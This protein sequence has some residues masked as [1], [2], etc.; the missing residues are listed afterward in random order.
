QNR[1]LLW[2]T[3]I[4]IIVA[5]IFILLFVYFYISKVIDPLILLTKALQNTAPGEKIE[6]FTLESENEIGSLM[7]SYNKLNERISIL[8]ERVKNNEAIKR[9]IELKELQ[10]Q[11]KPYFLNNTVASINWTT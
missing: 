3:F 7:T 5:S 4:A 1:Y 8:M 11:I 9:Q 10:K 6:G 2:F